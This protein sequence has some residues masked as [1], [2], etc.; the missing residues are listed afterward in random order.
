VTTEPP[1]IVH[2]LGGLR[3]VDDRE[4]VTI[5]TAADQVACQFSAPDYPQLYNQLRALNLCPIGAEFLNLRSYRGLD[6]P[7]W[8]CAAVEGGFKIRVVRNFWAGAR[9]AAGNDGQT[10]IADL[11][12]RAS[13]YLDLLPIRILQ[14]SNA[15]NQALRSYLVERPAP[16]SLLFENTFRRYIDAA[17]HAFV[18]DAASFR[19]LIAESAWKLVLRRTSDVRSLK[20]FR[21]EAKTLHDPIARAI[22]TAA[23]PGG[24][25]KQLSDLRNHI[26]HV[27]PVG[28]GTR[29]Q[30]CQPRR[31]GIGQSVEAVGLHYPLLDE[32][33]E[34]REHPHPTDFNEAEIRRAL[35]DYKSF[36]DRSLDALEYAWA[37][38]DRLVGLLEQIG[39]ASGI[40]SE[41]PHL[42]DDDLI[43]D[44]T[45]T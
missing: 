30:L 41:I 23:A 20:G 12:G 26:T 8:Q 21:K 40:P 25:L 24:W 14:L 5:Q 38:L 36:A 45:F 33:G 6:A 27:A 15:Y 4:Q 2:L 28:R 3:A 32:A 9:H 43:G 11:A 18:A 44:P 37:T 7:D 13:T 31:I 39:S 1:R 29:F 34:V 17:I 16:D 35:D 19:D 42:T 22:L 10:D